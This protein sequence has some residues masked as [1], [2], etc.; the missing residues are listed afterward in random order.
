MQTVTVP[1]CLENNDKE[2]SAD[3]PADKGHCS[4][5]SDAQAV[6]GF[7]KTEET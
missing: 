3:V 7:T 2:N 4:Q 1:Y 6:N 5:S